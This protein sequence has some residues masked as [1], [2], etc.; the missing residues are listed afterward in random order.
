MDKNVTI[1]S[2]DSMVRIAA[3]YS[4]SKLF[5]LTRLHVCHATL[6]N[7]SSHARSHKLRS[8]HSSH[9]RLVHTNCRELLCHAG[10]TEMGDARLGHSRL[11]H[12]S[13]TRLGH[14]NA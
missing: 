8:A 9:S 14:A 1:K 2:G 11:D 7:L 12:T 4:L 10:L 13:H 3:F 6:H 5:C